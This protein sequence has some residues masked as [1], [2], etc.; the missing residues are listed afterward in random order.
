MNWAPDCGNQRAPLFLDG[1][2]QFFHY[3]YSVLKFPHIAI[4]LTE[5]GNFTQFD[6]PDKLLAHPDM[7]PS[8]YQS[9]QFKKYYTEKGRTK[10][11]YQK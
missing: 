6:F 7:V 11:S 10:L 8:T 1:Y 9:G 2:T 3:H 4:I 5:V